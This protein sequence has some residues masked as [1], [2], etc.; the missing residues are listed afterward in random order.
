MS[1]LKPELY[2]E[3]VI[4]GIN[5]KELVNRWK[6]AKDKAES[7]DLIFE[8]INGFRIRT[9]IEKDNWSPV[10]RTATIASLRNRSVV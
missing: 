9:M 2:G 7:N 1:I 5:E 8:D 3:V 4:S 10:G 6:N